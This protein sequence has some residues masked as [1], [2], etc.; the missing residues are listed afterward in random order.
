MTTDIKHIIRR[1]SNQL[2]MHSGP[3][4]YGVPSF[5]YIFFRTHALT[6][7]RFLKSDDIPVFTLEVFFFFHI[8]KEIR[9]L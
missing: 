8:S 4:T 3:M 5:P 6:Y 1:I 2:S 7:I 9:Y